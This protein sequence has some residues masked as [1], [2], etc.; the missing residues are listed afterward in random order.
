MEIASPWRS[1]F[2]NSTRAEE[3]DLRHS[4]QNKLY[5]NIRLGGLSVNVVTGNRDFDTEFLIRRLEASIKRHNGLFVEPSTL[6]QCR[7]G[8]LKIVLF[9]VIRTSATNS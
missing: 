1:Q 6:A 4:A 7:L 8:L 2:L 5:R 3:P 9:G